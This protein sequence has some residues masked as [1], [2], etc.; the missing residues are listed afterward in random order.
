MA[1]K[2]KEEL[3]EKTGMIKHPIKSYRF[4]RH[5]LNSKI[6]NEVKKH[7]DGQVKNKEKEQLFVIY[8]IFVLLGILLCL[9]LL[10]KFF[11]G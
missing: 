1:I 10:L 2:K 8:S 11:G 7:I 5:R 4:F 3:I 6:T 9:C